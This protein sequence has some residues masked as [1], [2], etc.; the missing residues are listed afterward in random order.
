MIISIKGDSYTNS[1]CKNTLIDI[2]VEQIIG[3]KTILNLKGTL[4]KVPFV[5]DPNKIYKLK[6]DK[7]NTISIIEQNKFTHKQGENTRSEDN[8]NHKQIIDDILIQL[9]SQKSNEESYSSKN[10]ILLIFH[11]IS[12]FVSNKYNEKNNKKSIKYSISKNNKN[13]L[14]YFNMKFFDV[15][16]DVIIKYQDSKIKILIYTEKDRISIDHLKIFKEELNMVIN[17]SKL[18]ELG[19]FDKK[20]FNNDEHIIMDDFIFNNLDVFA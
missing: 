20:L 5:L 17:D 13:F 8:K 2:K 6:I 11:Q 15:P 1:L 16:S 12:D 7:N 4:I 14:F 3:N 10:D 18:Y 19:I 9:K